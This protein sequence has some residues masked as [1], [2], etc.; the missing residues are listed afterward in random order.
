MDKKELK[1]IMKEYDKLIAESQIR[2]NEA[3]KRMEQN[4]HLLDQ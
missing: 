3:A 2:F 4:F 1:K